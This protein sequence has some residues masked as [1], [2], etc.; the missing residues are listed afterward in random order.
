MI[1]IS[2]YIHYWQYQSESKFNMLCVVAYTPILVLV[3]CTCDRGNL[4]PCHCFFSLFFSFF[5]EA[6]RVCAFLCGLPH[7]SRA[8]Y[9]YTNSTVVMVV[10]KKTSD[11]AKPDP[12]RCNRTK[13]STIQMKRQNRKI[14]MN[15]VSHNN[16]TETEREKTQHW[17]PKKAHDTNRIATP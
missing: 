11:I 10:G 15:A 14:K 1:S 17:W 2:I 8:D 5:S 6:R 7:S 13:N 16:K 3:E 12:S 4:P 9:I